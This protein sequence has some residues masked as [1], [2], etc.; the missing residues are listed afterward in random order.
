MLSSMVRVGV[1]KWLVGSGRQLEWMHQ[2]CRPCY[3][4]VMYTVS[5]CYFAQR[6]VC[7]GAGRRRKLTD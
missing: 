6:L 5:A 3:A 1:G 4:A 7:T 2:V